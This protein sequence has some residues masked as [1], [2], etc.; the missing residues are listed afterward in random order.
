M[1]LSQITAGCFLKSKKILPVACSGSPVNHSR[2]A[3]WSRRILGRKLLPPVEVFDSKGPAGTRP[4]RVP[5]P[6]TTCTSLVIWTFTF[7]VKSHFHLSFLTIEEL[8]S[9]PRAP[10]QFYPHLTKH[11]VRPVGQPTDSTP[12]LC[13]RFPSRSPRAPATPVSGASEWIV[14]NLNLS[15]T[16]DSFWHAARC[17]FR[18]QALPA[19]EARK[20]VGKTPSVCIRRILESVCTSP[21]PAAPPAYLNPPLQLILQIITGSRHC[22]CPRACRTNSSYS[23]QSTSEFSTDPAQ[24]LARFFA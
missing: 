18:T 22:Q 11:V 13:S 20:T 4:A 16:Y 6:A 2:G 8:F 7:I 10:T 17:R 1:R 3:G 12:Q 14:L 9:L 24:T 23:Q 15:L 5:T 21:V 19:S